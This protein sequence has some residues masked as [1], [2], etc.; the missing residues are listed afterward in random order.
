VK[1]TSIPDLECM[2]GN[3]RRTARA[4]TQ[5]YE[6]ALRP[7]GLRTTQ[8]TVLQVLQRVGE[9]LQGQLGEILAMD[10]TSL[11][12]TLGIMVQQGWVAER[13]GR[14]RRERWLRLAEGGKE[15]LGEAMPVW[16]GVQARLRLRFG[17]EQ[18]GNFSRMANEVTEMVKGEAEQ[19]GEQ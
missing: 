9:V 5:L 2:C 7:L 14:D 1:K 4:L 17:E 11:T 16:E 15:L 19:K 13:R 12:R 8:F 6:E 3:V 18:W 10:S